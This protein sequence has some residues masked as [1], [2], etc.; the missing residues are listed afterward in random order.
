MLEIRIIPSLLLKKQGLIKTLRFKRPKYVGDPIN[1]IRIFNEKEVDELI[2]F[3]TEASIENR[4]P[5]FELISDVASE[6]FMPFG[7]GGGVKSLS[8]IE[9]ILGI[10]AEKVIINSEAI[11]NPKLI[12]EA[13]IRF[14]SQSIVVSIDV[15]RNFWGKY[16]VY[17]HS[18]KSPTKSDPVEFS[19][20]META[21]AG[22]VII[23]SVDRDGTMK[24]YDI[25]LISNIS[26]VLDIPVVASGGAGRIEDFIEVVQKGGASAVTA[27]S[28]FV[29]KGKHRAV[30]ISY[31]SPKE[32][33]SLNYR[34]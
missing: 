7:Y 23:T 2:L 20:L 14:G 15:K 13:A 26:E 30:L 28:M 21:G 12:E 18:G 19:K 6:C 9:K 29:F 11:R 31:P 17:S 27:G 1:A 25:D 8:D 16:T 32:I 22:E 24:G 33:E 4:D 34:L 10:G 3:D 5:D